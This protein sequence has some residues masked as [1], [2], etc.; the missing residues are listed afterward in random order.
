MITVRNINMANAAAWQS[1]HNTT[2]ENNNGPKAKT[3]KSTAK[4]AI[5]R[6]E[7]QHQ[8]DRNERRNEDFQQEKHH[9][10]DVIL[11]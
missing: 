6:K 3:I 10:N 11:K 4:V 1:V 5:R 2:T 9:Q 7:N 8:T